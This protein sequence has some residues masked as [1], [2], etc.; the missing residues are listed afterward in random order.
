MMSG[1]ANHIQLIKS[2][3]P[4]IFKPVNIS[5]PPIHEKIIFKDFWAQASGGKCLFCMPTDE[6]YDLIKK[7]ITM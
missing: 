7:T 5:C 2:T 6:G 3:R 1:W 4:L